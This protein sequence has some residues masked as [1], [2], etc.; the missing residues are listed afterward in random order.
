MFGSF[1][2]S[3]NLQ[4]CSILF[5]NDYFIHFSL[6]ET[7]MELD[8]ILFQKYDKHKKSYVLICEYGKTKLICMYTIKPQRLEMVV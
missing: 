1:E 4:M 8:N 6:I 3:I 2:N 7:W 5:Y